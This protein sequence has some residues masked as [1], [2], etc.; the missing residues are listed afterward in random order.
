MEILEQLVHLVR[1]DLLESKVLQ[2]LPDSL[3][4]LDLWDLPD[5][6]DHRGLRDCRVL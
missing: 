6:R 1:Q 2:E 4:L 3:D 5:L